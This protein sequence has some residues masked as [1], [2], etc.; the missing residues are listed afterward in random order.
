MR[1]DIVIG[2]FDFMPNTKS[3]ERRMRQSTRRHSRNTSTLNRLKTLEKRYLT[4][5]KS[6][7]KDD[8][9]KVLAEVNSAFDKA[10]KR[11]VIHWAKANRKKSRL[12]AQLG[13]TKAA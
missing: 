13:K 2:L 1:L 6:G 10:A 3:A 5:V 7:K 12:S 9:Q 4:T 8:A 11:G